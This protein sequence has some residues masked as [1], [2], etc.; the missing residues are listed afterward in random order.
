MGGN[1]FIVLSHTPKPLSSAGLMPRSSLRVASGVILS[2]IALTS[3]REKAYVR[4]SLSL[5]SLSLSPSLC[6]VSYTHLTLP[7]KA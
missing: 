5:F 2:A 7:T 1:S 6:P 4:P 3:K